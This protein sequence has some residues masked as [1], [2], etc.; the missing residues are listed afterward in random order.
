MRTGAIKPDTPTV[1]ASKRLTLH[2]LRRAAPK[3]VSS[4]VLQVAFTSQTP[5]RSESFLD[6]L[7][8]LEDSFVAIEKEIGNLRSI[9]FRNPSL[10]DFANVYL[11][12]NSD[13]LDSLVSAPKYFDQIIFAFSLAMRETAVSG[14][15][16][17]GSTKYC[18]K[19]PGIKAWVGRRANEFIEMAINLLNSEKAGT[20]Y[21]VTAKSRLG[22]LLSV[23]TVYGSPTE[24]IQKE[25]LR[26]A[27]TLA[28]NPHGQNAADIMLRLLDRPSYRSLLDQWLKGD[29]AAAMRENVLDQDTWKFSVLSRLDELLDLSSEESRGSWGEEYLDYA[30]QRAEDLADSDDDDDLREAIEEFGETGDMLGIDLSYEIS[31]LEERRL[32]LPEEADYDENSS[33]ISKTV[34]VFDASAQLDEIF[35]S[36]L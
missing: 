21:T 30:R 15:G 25:K 16:K 13:W 11:D 3:P 32:K 14:S 17:G 8:S 24:D 19:Y 20:P 36:L 18:A 7:R 23:V 9:S 4:D 22:E 27:V 31:M 26:D 12:N 35:A 34:K 33:T 1:S 2:H 5:S 28:V 10:E 6:S 29:A